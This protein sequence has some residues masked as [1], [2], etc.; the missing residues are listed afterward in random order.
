MAGRT[1]NRRELRRQAD[2]AEQ[3]EAVAPGVTPAEAPPGKKDKAKAPAAPRAR[4]PRAPK[5]PP[6]L[7][8][9][10][11]VFDGGM[12][13]VAIFDYN[14]R[15]AADAKLADLTAKKKGTHFLQI[16][17]DLMPEPMPAEE[18]PLA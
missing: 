13:Q 15:A 8:A 1:L 12:K 3:A 17:K 9:R 7:R 4:K 5:V 16:V 2:Q 6:R 10:W 11:G 14:Q 18:A